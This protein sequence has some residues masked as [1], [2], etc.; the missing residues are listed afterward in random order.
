MTESVEW[1][2][3]KCSVPG[4]GRTAMCRDKI[5]AVCDYAHSGEEVYEAHL[6]E[7]IDLFSLPCDERCGACGG[8]LDHKFRCRN[9]SCGQHYMR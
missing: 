9:L 7:L 3:E 2:V 1:I 8:K 6:N 5:C 4:C